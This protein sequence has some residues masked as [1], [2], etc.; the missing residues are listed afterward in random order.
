[1]AGSI[2]KSMATVSGLTMVSRVL[3]FARQILLAGI[4]GASGNPVADAFWA[5]FRL[6]N[7]FRRLLAEGA[8]QAAFVP[9]FQGHAV[10]GDQEQAKKFAEDILAWLIVILTGLCAIMMIFT[11]FFVSLLATGFRDDPERFGLTVLY[12]RI[13]FPYLVCMSLVG[14]YGGMLNALH[15]FAAAAAAPL[16]LNVCFIVGVLAFADE[17][18]AIT[19]RAAAWSVMAGGVLQLLALTYAASRSSL[20]TAAAFAA[21]YR[22][23]QA[24]AGSGHPGLYRRGGASGE[25]HCRHQYLPAAKTAPCRG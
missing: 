19:G 4:I 12:T 8:F 24:D 18:A 7:M 6:P 25:R 1:M 3:G 22:R 16:L 17:P 14:L 5:A 9:L 21:L 20:F 2:L 10:N 13:M 23:G 11:P 15:R